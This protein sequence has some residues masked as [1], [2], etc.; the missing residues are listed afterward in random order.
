MLFRHH[1]ASLPI[2]GLV[3]VAAL[4]SG[5]GS[6]SDAPAP[7]TTSTSAGAPAPA[8]ADSSARTVTVDVSDMSFAPADITISAG[9]TVTWKFDDR[10]PHGVQGIGDKAMAINSPLFEQ[11]EWSHTFTHPGTYRY[12]CPLHPDM[13][14]T[15]TVE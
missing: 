7:A 14:G 6:D 1:A 12:L 2:A 9:D 4:L 11:G 5:C 8:P 3:L 13:R 15:V 10:F